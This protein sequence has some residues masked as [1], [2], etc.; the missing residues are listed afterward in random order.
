MKK[1]ILIG[2][3]VFGLSI[4]SAC[5]VFDGGAAEPYLAFR[6][7]DAF[8]QIGLA[9]TLMVLWLQFAAYLFYGAITRRVA[10]PWLAL[11]IWIGIA[12]FYL[13]QSPVGYVGD[14]T[15]FVIEKQ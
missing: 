10:R 4:A 5:I 12:M 2:V 1:N 7:S 14:I 13:W 6:F 3:Y 15:K 9:I 11:S 8:V